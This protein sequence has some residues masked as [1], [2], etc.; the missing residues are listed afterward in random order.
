[1]KVMNLTKLPRGKF[2]RKREHS[3]K[4]GSTQPAESANFYFA[5]ILMFQCILQVLKYI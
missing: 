4:L 3:A 5:V 1:M 2:H